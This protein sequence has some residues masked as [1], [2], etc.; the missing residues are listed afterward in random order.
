[1]AQCS[2]RNSVFPPL[3]IAINGAGSVVPPS[4]ALVLQFPSCLVPPLQAAKFV[5]K[6]F[7]VIIPAKILSEIYVLLEQ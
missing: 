4:K 7:G 6:L 3:I 2:Y 5:L 1:M